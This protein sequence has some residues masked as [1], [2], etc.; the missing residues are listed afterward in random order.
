MNVRALRAGFWLTAGLVVRLLREGLVL[1]SMIFPGL[2]TAVTLAVTL[3]VLAYSAPGRTVLVTPE[4]PAHLVQKM[5][6]RDLRV[7]VEPD[8]RRL[9]LGGDAAVGTDG[10][11]L[12]VYGAAPSALEVEAMIRAERGATWSPVVPEKPAPR[13]P[14]ETLDPDLVCRVVGLLFSLYGLVFGLGGVARDRDAGILEAE[15]ALPIPRFVG[16]FARWLASSLVLAAFFGLTVVLLGAL[17]PLRAPWSVLTHGW[18]ASFGAVAIGIAVVGTSGLRQ[19]FSGPFALGMTLATAVGGTGATLG[20]HFLP[21]G[22]L[23]SREPG[24]TSLA[25]SIL[26]GVVASALYGRRAGGA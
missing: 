19:G 14:N 13:D 5:R 6:D 9:V 21:M 3:G 26:F 12:W 8:A 1:R 24:W 2:V 23:L 22:S 16:G 4:T 7:L 10:E 20:L 11:T 15:L 18:A 17:L 25:V